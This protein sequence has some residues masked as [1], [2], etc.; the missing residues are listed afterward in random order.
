MKPKLVREDD[1]SAA[2][3][4]EEVFWPRYPRK[5]GKH[6]ALK[7]WAK[8]KLQDDDQETLDH[9]MRGLEHYLENEWDLSRPRFI[10]HAST[11]L[12]QRRWEDVA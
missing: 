12:N 6:E 5:T 11:W 7:A 3:A 10:T 4:F 2:D 1:L 9:I 8:L